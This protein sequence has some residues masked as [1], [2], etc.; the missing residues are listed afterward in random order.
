MIQPIRGDRHG[1]GRAAGRA[2]H[3]PADFS[4]AA[5]RCRSS[6]RTWPL[7][8]LA[9]PWPSLIHSAGLPV[10]PGTAAAR[11]VRAH[12]AA[13]GQYRDGKRADRLAI[14]ESDRG[15]GHR[16]THSHTAIIS[17]NRMHDVAIAAMRWSLVV[18]L[19]CRG[20]LTTA[21]FHA[22]AGRRGRWPP[23][24]TAMG[25]APAGSPSARR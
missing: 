15:T 25:S 12:S 3:H 19:P 2:E 16:I 9:T 18:C 4:P 23:R 5:A 1:A 22:Y 8:T 21:S 7:E 11:S 6:S 17:A 10:G 20:L 13:R 14:D 24:L